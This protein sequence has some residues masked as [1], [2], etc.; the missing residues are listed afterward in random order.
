ML[1]HVER[2]AR[3]FA[4][5]FSVFFFSAHFTYFFRIDSACILCWRRSKLSQFIY[6]NNVNEVGLSSCSFSRVWFIE[7]NVWNSLLMLR[8]FD[9]SIR[10]FFL[11]L[12]LILCSLGLHH[13]FVC[14]CVDVKYGRFLFVSVKKKLSAC[15]VFLRSTL[16]LTNFLCVFNYKFTDKHTQ[17][18][19]DML[20]VFAHV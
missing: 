6:N 12:L 7:K 11:L 19:A 17:N 14:V 8:L 10:C 13:L 2:C 20:P 18:D 4:L 5:F 3:V 15:N 16:S 9:C 1:I